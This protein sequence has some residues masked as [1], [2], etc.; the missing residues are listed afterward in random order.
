M[1]SMTVRSR[2]EKETTMTSKL[3]NMIERLNGER[4]RR[5][6]P[7]PIR[8]IIGVGFMVHGWAKWS[9]GPAAFAELLKQAHVPLPLANAWLV[10]FLEIFGGLAILI[11]AF[12]AVVSIPLIVS[13]LGAIFTV[14]I[15]YG[16]SAVKTI[17]L[18]PEGPQFGP[19]G[20][21]INLLYIA[22]LVALIL[23]GAGPL[24][25]DSL[26]K[27]RRQRRYVSRP[28]EVVAPIEEAASQAR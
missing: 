3:I 8:M 6:A 18:T 4:W 19:P 17:G 16:F 25:I 23:A 20:Y 22:G 27:R 9:R 24:S 26:R 12:A 5:W 14:N 13:M 11:G 28:R 1:F 10:T 2:L 7:V 15:H 21:E